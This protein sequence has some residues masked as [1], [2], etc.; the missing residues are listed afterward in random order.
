M[1][2]GFAVA[3]ASVPY[4]V[5]FTVLCVELTAYAHTQIF[6]CFAS[7]GVFFATLENTTDFNATHGF[8]VAEIL[9]WFS[10][11][12]SKFIFFF[13]VTEI[14]DLLRIFQKIMV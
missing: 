14:N 4:T 5:R 10:E 2:V 3:N 9:G 11:T 6:D 1:I 12:S 13:S 8:L 7:T